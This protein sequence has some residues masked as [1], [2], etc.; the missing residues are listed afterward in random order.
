MTVS[1][2]RKIFLSPSEARIAPEDFFILL[3]YAS[4]KEQVFLLAHPEY[5]L[6]IAAETKVR[7]CFARRAAH[8]PVASIIGRKEF[9]GRDFL[10]TPDT[11]IPR[12]E[13]ELIV[14]L[15]LNEVES[16]KLKVESQITMIDIGTGS[17]NI[18]ISLA[19]ERE[20][21]PPDSSAPSCVL[22]AIDISA[23]ALAVAREN[24]RRQNV[25]NLIRFHEGDLLAPIITELAL[26]GEIIIAANLPYL[27]S[28]MYDN[29]APDVHDFEPKSALISEEAGLAHYYR[30]LRDVKKFLHTCKSVVLFLEISPEQ[31]ALLTTRVTALFPAAQTIIHT[32]LAHRER[33]VEIRREQIETPFPN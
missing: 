4:K 29:T 11:L 9:Y 7:E 3:A 20:K 23:G 5:E 28:S 32:D 21:Q 25:D 31:A 2:L 17:G 1:E 19:K 13:T 12:P 24:A 6:D 22:H 27:S 8:E 33:V 18:I 26:A 15:V 10:V 14:E 16:R 30:L